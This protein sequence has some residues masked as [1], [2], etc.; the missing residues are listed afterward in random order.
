ME[1]EISRCI[2]DL[3]ITVDRKCSGADRAGHFRVCLKDRR[4]CLR[5]DIHLK[6][7]S[8]R[9]RIDGLTTFRHIEMDADRVICSESLSQKVDPCH[10]KV[11]RVERIHTAFRV[12]AC[13]GRFTGE[14]RTLH[15]KAV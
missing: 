15:D 4:N 12:C 1:R 2:L 14:D 10:G 13:V 7:C 5:P 11:Y 8:S 6:L 3:K 9:N